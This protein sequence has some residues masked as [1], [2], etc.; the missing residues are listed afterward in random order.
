MPGWGGVQPHRPHC[1]LACS[2]MFTRA[3]ALGQLHPLH[4]CMTAH[5]SSQAA[6][7]A[8]EQLFSS[9]A[10]PAPGPHLCVP[11]EV[12]PQRQVLLLAR[13]VD[14]SQL[15]ALAL[16]ALHCEAYRGGQLLLM[17]ARGG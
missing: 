10:S 16:K 4:A 12:L 17:Q 7:R 15:A 13:H 1:L 9:S 5:P 8:A 2:Q 11:K 3:A 6:S 14:H